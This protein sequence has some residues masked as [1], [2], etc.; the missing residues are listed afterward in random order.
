MKRKPL[1]SSLCRLAHWMRGVLVEQRKAAAGL[2]PR[3]V[4]DLRVAL[5]RCRSIADVFIE[6]DPEPADW[7]AMRTAARSLFKSLGRLRDA[8]VMARWVERLSPRKD[9]VGREMAALLARR[10]RRLKKKAQ[11]AIER[12]DRKQWKRWSKSLPR[13]SRIRLK[14][15]RQPFERLVRARFEEA[16]ELHRRAL[17]DRSRPAWHR[18]RIALK[19]FRYSVENFLPER[20]AEWEKDLKNLQDTLGEVHDLDVLWE[21]LK[22]TGPVFDASERARWR[23]R[24]DR[25]R[26]RR[27]NAYRRKTVGKQ[28]LWKRWRAARFSSGS[29][30]ATTGKTGIDPTH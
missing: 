22:E 20:Y 29:R 10:T 16:F 5:R 21:A 3:R 24:I 26:G 9:P 13:R 7:K 4:H 17:R 27:L 23:G 2:S 19:R 25:E 1:S 11:E 28:S 30:T 15:D 12:F 18:L 8:Q 14:E 6:V